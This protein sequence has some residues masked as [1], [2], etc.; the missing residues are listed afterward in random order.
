MTVIGSYGEWTIVQED[1][2]PAGYMVGFATGGQ[3][4]LTNPLGIREH[5]NTA[6]RG[7]RLVKGRSDDYPL[8]EAY[9]QRG[10]G[11]GIA[12]RGGAVV[13]K[14]TTGAYTIPTQYA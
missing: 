4:S 3:D 10:F 6:L 13:M 5:A 8:Q 9:Y 14:I 2:I 12:Q 11:V 1:Y 7:L